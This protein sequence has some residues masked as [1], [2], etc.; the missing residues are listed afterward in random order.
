MTIEK[1]IKIELICLIIGTV[2]VGIYLIFICSQKPL[3]PLT[4]ETLDPQYCEKDEDC[5]CE[6]L[7][8]CFMGNKYYYEICINE[9]IK[10]SMSCQDLCMQELCRCVN[11][12]CDCGHGFS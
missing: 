2:L 6:Q 4:C 7:R 5:V 3:K 8:G 1:K 9:S 12:K 10:S 11:N